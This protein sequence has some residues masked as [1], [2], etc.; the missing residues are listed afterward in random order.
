MKTMNY[1]VNTMESNIRE[2]IFIN[3]MPPA[4]YQIWT[5]CGG[6]IVFLPLLY[7]VINNYDIFWVW[8]IYLA[9]YIPQIRYYIHK[10][11]RFITQIEIDPRK[12]IIIITSCRMLKISQKIIPF[13]NLTFYYK[14]IYFSR[15]RPIIALSFF[16]R[17]NN[18]VYL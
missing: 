2:R 4:F 10:L 9:S 8:I 7:F 6:I 3:K 1:T 13:E 17:K 5:S 14:E 15:G 18:R 16:D 11:D 12:K